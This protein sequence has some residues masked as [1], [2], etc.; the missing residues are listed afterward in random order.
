MDLNS[1]ELAGEVNN[2]VMAAVFEMLRSTI[3]NKCFETCVT[4]P[5]SSLSGSE[6]QCLAKCTDRFVDALQ[7]VAKATVEYDNLNSD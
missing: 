7:V 4:R 2:Q 6:Q 1:Q 3:T 5:S